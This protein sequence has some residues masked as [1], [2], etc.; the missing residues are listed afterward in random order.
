MKPCLMFWQ[1]TDLS[2]WRKKEERGI[3]MMHSYWQLHWICY[4]YLV[5]LYIYL[6][7][8]LRIFVLVWPWCHSNKDTICTCHFGSGDFGEISWCSGAQLGTR[9]FLGWLLQV[10]EHLSW[11]RGNLSRT[12]HGLMGMDDGLLLANMLLIHLFQVYVLP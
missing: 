10:S 6:S 2:L 3:C 9:P 8:H 5:Y 11:W 7:L 12:P 4:V 1:M